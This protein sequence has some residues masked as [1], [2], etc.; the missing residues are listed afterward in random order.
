MTQ[1]AKSG[2]SAM[3]FPIHPVIGI[4]RP[5]TVRNTSL[6]NTAF[7]IGPLQD[8]GVAL[9]SYDGWVT[10]SR[11]ELLWSS[12]QMVGGTGSKP[13]GTPE[14]KASTLAPT[15]V[16]PLATGLLGCSMR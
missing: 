15:Y 5:E 3:D 4:T 16:L 7:L 11:P 1:K 12:V 14:P 9:A 10:V 2:S 13:P 6:E 8:K